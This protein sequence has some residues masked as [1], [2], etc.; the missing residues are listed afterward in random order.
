MG[1]GTLP[2]AIL[3]QVPEKNR[4]GDLVYMTNNGLTQVSSRGEITQA[5]T[6]LGTRKVKP[7]YVANAIAL[8][9]RC[10]TKTALDP[11]TSSVL[12]QLTP[13]LWLSG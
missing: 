13:H 5:W 11:H 6:T 7:G 12:L 2:L 4:S 10:N 9:Y 8:E 1:T 3:A